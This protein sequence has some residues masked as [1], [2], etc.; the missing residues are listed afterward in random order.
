LCFSN[1]SNHFVEYYYPAIHIMFGNELLYILF[2][3]YKPIS[4][5]NR[6]VLMLFLIYNTKIRLL[7]HS[8]KLSAYFFMK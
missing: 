4:F 2:F 5:H 3:L 8:R 7:F 1:R 6:F